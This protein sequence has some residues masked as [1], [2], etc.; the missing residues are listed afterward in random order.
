MLGAGPSA[1]QAST[2]GFEPATF[3]FGGQRSIQLSY[4]DGG[5]S[6]AQASRTL[7]AL[8]SAESHTSN[9][10]PAGPV[11]ALPIATLT[12][13]CS[14][15]TGILWNAIYFIAQSQYGF[16]REKSLLLAF[17][18]GVLYAIVALGAG[19]LVRALE[20]KT[21]P[22]GALALVLTTQALL[23]P[24]VLVFPSEGVLWA[25]AIAMTAF[26]ALQWPIVQHYLVSGRH[27]PEM[28]G[29]IG[30]W[31]TSWM[32]ATA[33][34]L[35]A[36]GPLESLGLMQWA[37]PSLLPCNLLALFCLRWFP[38]HPAAHDGD[39]HHRHVPRSYRPLLAASRVLHPM[40]YLV[41]G[42]LAPILPYLFT[43]LATPASLHA[44]IGAIWHVAR[45]VAVLVLW[46]TAFW[47]GRGASLVVAGLLLSIGFATA[48]AAPNEAML[49]VGLIALGLGQGAIYYSAIYYGLAVGAAEVE[50]GGIHEAL[51]GMGYFIG[52]GIGLLTFAAGAGA[53]TF[54]LF[55]ILAL[56]IGSSIAWVRSRNAA[57]DASHSSAG[58]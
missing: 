13:L 10:R 26:G 12:F 31:N 42:A 9:A 6:V 49:A 45:V 48:V 23:A 51:V 16:T 7:R 39:E 11:H 57:R 19:R 2:A 18:N 17:V 25:S 44:P 5:R 43:N 58:A 37:I 20:A 38:K 15:G 46:R 54:I 50:A 22:R 40:G 30:W 21:S 55:V 33:L 34:G 41:I 24:M 14:L 8:I 35:A 56:A 53:P 3:A 29:A 32:A 47:H 1:T 36:T 4:A 28:R 27:G 52:P